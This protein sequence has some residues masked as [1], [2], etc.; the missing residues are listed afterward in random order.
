[1]EELNTVA[2]TVWGVEECSVT[3]FAMRQL[4]A[5][6]KSRDC[7]RDRLR[8]TEE[9]TTGSRFPG[10][11]LASLSLRVLRNFFCPRHDGQLR[12]PGG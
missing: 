3:A 2:D 7:L 10:F 12:C 5:S 1:M 11:D 8:D 6:V 4:L 9:L